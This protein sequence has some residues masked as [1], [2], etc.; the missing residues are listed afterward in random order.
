MAQIA[1]IF[2]GYEEGS[3]KV[4]VYCDMPNGTSIFLYQHE[5]LLGTATLT[6]KRCEITITAPLTDNGY[7]LEAYPVERLGYSQRVVSSNVQLTGWQTPSQVNYNG[8][9]ITYTAWQALMTTQP[10]QYREIADLFVPQLTTNKNPDKDS[11]LKLAKGKLTFSTEKIY[12]NGKTVVTIN[13][14]QNAYGGYTVQFDNGAVGSGL[15]KIYTVSGTYN[16]RVVDLD[17][18]ANFKEETFTITIINYV[19]PVTTTI[20]Q[21]AYQPGYGD[22]GSGS[23]DVGYAVAYCPQQVEFRLL[24]AV[25]TGW[26]DG[27]GGSNNRWTRIFAN[28]P[29]GANKIEARVKTNVSD[30]RQ[31]DFTQ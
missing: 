4:E 21:L 2:S 8:T 3:T 24:G 30:Y 16:V 22:N 15:S 14:I 11:L 25:P 26:V 12:E 20:E 10:Q 27:E 28:V 17:N 23:F 29:S 7:A 6:N 1:Y 31:Q 19:A 18:S 13:D 9:V 5:D